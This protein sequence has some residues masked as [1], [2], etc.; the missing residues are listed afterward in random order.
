[1]SIHKPALY[2]KPQGRA[3]PSQAGWALPL[4]IKPKNRLYGWKP[5]RAG[6]KQELHFAFQKKVNFAIF[7]DYKT[8][9]G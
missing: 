5:N 2:E 9:K 8:K 1:V 3:C 6:K 7:I 4:Q